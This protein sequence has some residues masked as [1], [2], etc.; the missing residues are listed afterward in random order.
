MTPG[1][2]GG[3]TAA[4]VGAITGIGSIIGMGFLVRETAGCGFLG[5]EHI[6][7]LPMLEIKFAVLVGGNRP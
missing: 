3:I 2:S 5:M 6:M 1:L 7:R 4:G